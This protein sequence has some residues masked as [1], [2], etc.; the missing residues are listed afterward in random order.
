MKIDR[1]QLLTAL[2]LGALSTLAAQGT[3]IEV[4]GKQVQCKA[5]AHTISFDD[6]Q[7]KKRTAV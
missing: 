4:R 6:P 5:V 7:K 2:G 3:R 1:R